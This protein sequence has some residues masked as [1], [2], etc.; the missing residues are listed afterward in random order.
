[1]IFFYRKIHAVSPVDKKEAINQPS[2]IAVPLWSVFNKFRRLRLASVR[3]CFTAI[4]HLHK[5]Q[6]RLNET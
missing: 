5:M 3:G 6:G 2:I 1:M 4:L